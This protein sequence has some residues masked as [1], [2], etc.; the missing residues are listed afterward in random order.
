[1]F[2][3]ET[4]FNRIFNMIILLAVVVAG[5]YVLFNIFGHLLARYGDWLFRLK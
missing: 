4:I 2:D 5:G 3:F 1:M